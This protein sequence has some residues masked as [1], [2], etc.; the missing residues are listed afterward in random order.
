METT[1]QVAHSLSPSMVTALAA[2]DFADAGGEGAEPSEFPI[3][4]KTEAERR[5]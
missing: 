1:A 5:S 3:E 4:S 2:T